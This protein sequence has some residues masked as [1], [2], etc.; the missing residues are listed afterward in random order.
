MDEPHVCMIAIPSD[1][2]DVKHWKIVSSGVNQHERYQSFADT[3]ASKKVPMLTTRTANQSQTEY[4]HRKNITI[5][6]TTDAFL[7]TLV[8]VT[9]MEESIHANAPG[10]TDPDDMIVWLLFK[11]RSG[12]ARMWQEFFS[13]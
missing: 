7:H 8:T 4:G 11:T 10:E 12:A 5:L 2:V 9:D 6:N 3:Q 1:E 13:Q